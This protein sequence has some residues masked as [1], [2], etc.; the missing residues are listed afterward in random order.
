[1]LFISFR[2]VFFVEIEIVLGADP[3]NGSGRCPS[4]EEYAARQ[5]ERV[6]VTMRCFRRTIWVARLYG[7]NHRFF[8]CHAKFNL[9]KGCFGLHARPVGLDGPL[10][11]S[12]RYRSRHILTGLTC[13]SNHQ[14]PPVDSFGFFATLYGANFWFSFCPVN[15]N[16]CESCFL[17]HASS[18]GLDGPLR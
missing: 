11:E 16:F 15:F 5:A 9:C 10:E 7:Y 13:P 1:M 6:L 17:L 4:K 14:L 18:V 3:G 2:Q 12:W 8:F